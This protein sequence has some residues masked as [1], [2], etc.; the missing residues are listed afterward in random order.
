[1]TFVF[2]FIYFLFNSLVLCWL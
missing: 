2:I 1:M